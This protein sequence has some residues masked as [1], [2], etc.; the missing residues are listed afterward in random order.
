MEDGKELERYYVDD[1]S[2]NPDY[3]RKDP[4]GEY[5]RYDQA[6]AIIAAKDAEI[7]TLEAQLAAAFEEAAKWLDDWSTQTMGQD[8]SPDYAAA[9]I[10]AR[11]V[12][13]RKPS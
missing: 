6:A 1:Q 12:L 5:V 3:M 4:E 2:L 8:V 7:A 9:A 13:G 10:R 11:A